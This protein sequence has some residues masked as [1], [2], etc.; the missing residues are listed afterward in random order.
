[1]ERFGD[2]A[3]QWYLATPSFEIQPRADN[4]YAIVYDNR[5]VPVWW[6]DVQSV[7]VDLKLLP[8][9]NVAWYRGKTSRFADYP[10]NA[11]EERELDG[12]LVRTLETDGSPTDLHE[13]QLMPNGNY[14]LVTYRDRTGVDLTP[15]GGP[16]DATVQD[17][18]V[19][20]VTPDGALVW[21]WNAKDHV[22]LDETDRWWP[23]VVAT[24]VETEAGPA[25]D[26]QH[27]N[28]VELDGDAIVISLRHTDA[29]YRIDRATGAVDWKL[30]GTATP[31]SLTFVGDAFGTSAF[32]G[33]HDP[34]VLPDGTVTLF[35]NGTDRSRAPRAVRYAID[36]VTRTA[37]L[38]EERRD[39]AFN[40][41]FCCGSARRLSGGGWG[42]YWGGTSSFGEL[43]PSG[44]VVLRVTWSNQL[45]YRA[46]PV[47]PGELSAGD[48]RSAM[49]VMNPR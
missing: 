48:L 16:A 31:A 37:T 18:E 22:S 39:P 34:R 20:E 10:S 38:V 23:T 47:E 9:G 29:V 32:G 36:P 33:Q 49:E 21:T 17:A 24:P 13:L 25:Y 15:Y 28:S 46:I 11:Y 30:G 42:V 26:H 6:R 45:S 43:G 1:V 3:A 14:L 5:G 40:G 7:P 19:Q 41:S 27:I 4:P 12:T 44:E 35:D 8:N 2:P